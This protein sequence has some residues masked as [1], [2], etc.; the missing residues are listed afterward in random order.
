[1]SEPLWIGD[2]HWRGHGP[3][4]GLCLL[5]AYADEVTQQRR[6]L[7]CWR[8]GS[9][10]W[11]WP[12]V[13][14]VL[15]SEETFADREAL[16]GLSLRQLG[17]ELWTS[18]P[19]PKAWAA[20]M[21]RGLWLVLGGQPRC[22][23]LQ[24]AA[25]VDL[26][27]WI[28][29]ADYPRLLLDP[30]LQPAEVPSLPDFAG[31]G[32]CALMPDLPE[33]SAKQQAWL[34]QFSKSAA[35]RPSGW[36]SVAFGVVGIFG[37]LGAILFRSDRQALA[38]AERHDGSRADTKSE[39]H[40]QDAANPGPGWP[41]RLAS[42]LI[43]RFR[44]SRLMG[45]M[46][47]AFVARMIQMFE[48]GNLGEALRHAL[49]L[50]QSG[51]P[52]QLNG[53][54]L[55]GPRATLEL[56]QRYH[57][58]V[59][60][61]LPEMLRLRLRALYR[62]AFE[63]LDRRGETDRAVYVL[64][65]LLDNKREA[66]DYLEKHGRL[67]QAAELAL[68]WEVDVAIQIRLLWLAGER[69]RAILIARRA[70][71]FAEVLAI[72]EAERSPHCEAVR[73]EF[74]QYLADRGDLVLAIEQAWSVPAMREQAAIWLLQAEAGS[75]V[76]L[77]ES[78]VL[79]ALLGEAVLRQ[80][81]SA[82]R[83][84]CEAVGHRATRVHLARALLARKSQRDALMPIARWLYPRVLADGMD[85]SGELTLAQLDSLQ[86]LARDPLLAADLPKLQLRRRP[87]GPALDNGFA[88][89]DLST[90]RQ[91]Y[92]A[93]LDIACVSADHYLIALGESGVVLVGPTGQRRAHFNVPASTLAVAE[94]GHLALAMI[95]RADAWRLT[96]IDLQRHR[97]QDYGRLEFNHFNP[98][99]RGV[100]FTI[101]D[102]KRI[103]VL[104]A[105]RD[106]QTVLWHVSDLPG[107]VVDAQF[108]PK[109]ELFLL[110]AQA[111]FERWHYLLPHRRLLTRQAWKPPDTSWRFL[112]ANNDQIT[113]QLDVRGKIATLHC[114]TQ[115]RKSFEVRLPEIETE[116][117]LTQQ[118]K[119]EHVPPGLL[120]QV[121]TGSAL[122]LLLINTSQSRE[123][124][125]IRWPNDSVV[126]W[127]VRD[128]D[129]FLFDQTGRF[130]HL[131]L[132][133]GEPRA[134]SLQ[135]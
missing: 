112:S 70:G 44:L 15:W 55:P 47:A 5:R 121:N 127:R 32:L 116:A 41:Q 81:E 90:L 10:V 52:N 56:G 12:E 36:Q 9:R 134:F 23:D 29:L 33:P 125:R 114:A 68:K 46:Q 49:P 82:L 132:R 51:P 27:T 37:A 77:A 113:V 101:V 117:A 16:H 7:Q 133:S 64:A 25:R 48:S 119:V 91:G 92:Q 28:D 54:W 126:S 99:I 58:S 122:W 57:T 1:M 105:A 19:I 97:W 83:D 73:A 110:Q 13:D 18:A 94:A 71:A 26:A 4:A 59:N 102:R 98:V 50:S 24:Q 108:G 88:T 30:S 128:E 86:Q 39:K 61:D 65:E 67:K 79:R 6:L 96:R 115:F 14:V 3:I 130:L 131:P 34:Q 120:V 31:Q 87:P 74:A 72:L 2:T 135:A 80:R 95:R 89:L 118:I 109:S 17:P 60:L 100:S 35:S 76:Q 11:R 111:G 22:F 106:A 62:Q 43:E 38:H 20:Q 75:Q 40:R 53:L 63:Q 84:V 103:L 93:A 42:A 107:L 85:G 78:L 129:L 8:P 104:D 21:Q 123:L 45:P 69:T 124:G 66:L